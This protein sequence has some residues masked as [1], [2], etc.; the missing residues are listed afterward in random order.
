MKA[1]TTALKVGK[2]IDGN[3][4]AVIDN[5]VILVEGKT[6]KQVGAASKVRVP[7]GAT[8]IDEPSLTA[9]PGM[10]DLHI[11]LCMFNNLTFKNYRV[12]Q[13]EVTP[14]LQQMYMLFHAQLCLERGFTT[15]R[16]LGIMTSRGLMTDQTAAVRDAIDN[17]ILGGPRLVC[18]AFTVGTGSHL[19]LINPRASLRNPEATA[20]GEDEMR[21]LAR[22][23]LLK[24]ADWLKTCASGGGGTDR[25]APDVRNHTQAELDAICDEAHA[26]HHYCSIHCFTPDAHRMAIKAGADTI[27]H[28]VF[29]DA[30]SI[31][32]LVEAQIPVTPTLLHRTDH[33]IEIRREI[34]TPKFTLEK[35]KTIQPNCFKTFQVMHKAGVKIAMGTDMGFEPDM[36]S[37]ASELALYVDLGMTP[38]EAI[39]TATRNAAE[40]LHKETEIGTLEAGKFAD[41]VLVN[42]NPAED[43]KVLEPRENIKMVYKEGRCMVDRREGHDIRVI[44]ADYG[45]WR[46]ADA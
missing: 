7:D 1:A 27:E 11:H 43:I 6:I 31:E 46:I 9:M 36:G 44:P 15:L 39:M 38:M 2:L 18:G 34:G 41:I 24:G 37:N 22:R 14:E 19:D 42:G 40:A 30:D 26:Q 23:N 3:G 35:M 12:A 33:A 29:H 16:D 28:M 5:A 10:M 32:R 25:E 13:W 45:S 17:G 4:G 20:D 21:K 8:I